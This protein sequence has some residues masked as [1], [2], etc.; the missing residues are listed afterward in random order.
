MGWFLVLT[1]PRW[2]LPEVEIMRPA[3]A[4]SKIVPIG[5]LLVTAAAVFLPTLTGRWTLYPTDI[6][7][8]MFL[9]FAASR[10]DAKVQDVPVSD[11]VLAYYPMHLFQVE[12]LLSGRFPLWNPYIFG[13]HPA[14]ASSGTVVTL[15]PF[16]AL[17]LMGDMGKGLAWRTFLQVVACMLFMFLFLREMG[18]GR[19]AGVVGSLGYGLNS[20]FWPLLFDR[21]MEEM[22]WFPLV[23]LLLFRSIR[24]RSPA[25]SLLSG[26]IL[27]MAL[28][29]SPIQVYAYI[30]IGIAALVGLHALVFGR[31]EGA[32]LT[33][34]F[35][36]GVA[37]LVGFLVSA[38]QLIPTLEFMAQSTRLSQGLMAGS[39]QT[40][41][42]LSDM[43]RATVALVLFV[44]P[45]LA[46]RLKDSMSVGTPLLGVTSHWQGYIGVVPFFLASVAVFAAKDRRRIVYAI[47]ALLVVV[48]VI[49]T[50]LVVVLYDRF[51]ILYI[52]CASVLAAIGFEAL[53][54]MDLDRRR[55]QIVVWCLLGVVAMVLTGLVAGNILMW[56]RGPQV[57]TFVKGQVEN[58]VGSKF[59]GSGNLDVYLQRALNYLN[60]E[61]LTNPHTAVPLL[62]ALLGLGAIGARLRN[63]VTANAF[64]AVAV[65]V[66]AADLVFMTLTNVPLVDLKENPFAPTSSAID[67]IQADQ[68]LYRIMTITM[69]GTK[70]VLPPNLASMYG[71]QTVGGYDDLAPPNVGALV[72]VNLYPCNGEQCATLSGSDIVNA[73]YIV[74]SPGIR[75]PKPR[76]ELVYD[77]EVRVYRDTTVLPRVFL[78]EGYRV[79]PDTDTALRTFGSEGFDPREQVIVDRSPGV[80]ADGQVPE[81]ASVRVVDYEPTA[82]TVAVVSPKAGIL[83][84]SDTFYS[85][86][87][88]SL[89]GVSVPLLRADG[90]LRAVAFEP[91]NHIVR[92]TYR[93]SSV[94]VG[95]AITLATVGVVLVV[96]ACISVFKDRAPRP[97]RA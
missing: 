87:V 10:S 26:L 95:A 84:L 92:F 46:G 82:V 83:V 36:G 25:V 2:R 96:V 47:T 38:V 39:A 9:P 40:A 50:P 3:S 19:F 71:L 53:R 58:S 30:G 45:N 20:M 14:F 70:P 67:A 56:A 42:S 31:K 41:R 12:T 51:L 1:R 21:V 61:K 66:T 16:N 63:R 97:E 54:T 44:F 29:A 13:G 17:L 33:H 75:L 79:I 52:F 81:G 72:S 8:K 57:V 80:Q 91:G 74:S 59:L 88:A 23:C 89:D 27:G 62:I 60:D 49:F 32:G 11:F 86:W 18:L 34:I 93:P 78:M 4:F 48:V 94:S 65:L 6:T 68:S 76:Y 64:G 77:K 24:L 85:G 15:D 28:L 43:L 22:L 55:A 37:L 73:K 35:Y 7:S 5:V 90:V 69:P